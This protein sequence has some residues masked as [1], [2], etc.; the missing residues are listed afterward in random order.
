LRKLDIERR[1][2]VDEVVGRERQLFE[3]ADAEGP[4]RQHV[5]VFGEMLDEPHLLVLPER[6]VELAAI[7]EAAEPV[8]AGSI[9]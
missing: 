2:G 9:Q 5:R 6:D 4:R 1:I 8:V 7:V 3:V